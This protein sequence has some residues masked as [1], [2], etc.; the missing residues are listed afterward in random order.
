MNPQKYSATV[1]LA[2]AAEPISRRAGRSLARLLPRI[3][4]GYPILVG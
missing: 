3:R 2:S 1:Q 4:P